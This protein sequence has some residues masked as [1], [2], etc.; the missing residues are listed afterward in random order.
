MAQKQFDTPILLLGFIRHQS[1]QK[2]FNEIRKVR[3]KK[4]FLAV[5][6][7][8]E[9]KPGEEE[10]CQATRNIAN[11]VDWDCEVKTLFQKNNLGCGLGSVT[12]INWFFENVEDGI[13]FDDDCLPNQ[14]FFYFCQE[15]LEYYRNNEK[16]MHIGGNNFQKG[17]KRG[18]SSYYFSQYTH[19]WGWA[20]WRRAWKYNDFGLISAD[21]Q[22]HIWDKQWLLSVRKKKGLAILPNLNLVSNIG[23]GEGATHTNEITEHLNLPTQEII[24]PLIHPKIILRHRFADYFSYCNIYE[25][26]LKKLIFQKIMKMTPKSLKLLAKNI[27]HKK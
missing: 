25:G 1:A 21:A 17:K 18:F 24:F 6:G 19:N 2:V 8:R 26:N 20:T 16:I 22:K 23:F 11:Q 14:S 15:L 13:I 7:P 27:L 9:N 12:A 5:D 10:L 4:F 3:P